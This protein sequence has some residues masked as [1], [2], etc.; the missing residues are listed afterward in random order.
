MAP[1]DHPESPLSQGSTAGPMGNK[2]WLPETAGSVL[3]TAVAR[4]S[5]ILVLKR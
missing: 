5:D 2:A 3:G 4:A 1:Q